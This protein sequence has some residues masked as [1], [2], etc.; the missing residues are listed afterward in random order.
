MNVL[1]SDSKS[2]SQAM[3]FSEQN[4]E[5][6]VQDV[7]R[8][9]SSYEIYTT[10]T[11]SISSTVISSNPR[12]N[13][14]MNVVPSPPSY[15]LIGDRGKLVSHSLDQILILYLVSGNQ[16]ERKWRVRTFFVIISSPSL[17]T[18][19]FMLRSCDWSSPV[20]SRTLFQLAP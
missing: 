3:N 18:S 10:S 19:N 8:I 7:L 14:I 5:Q 9:S 1:L 20:A 16:I 17:G 12:S 4:E 13:A 2:T 15:L 11:H 6:R